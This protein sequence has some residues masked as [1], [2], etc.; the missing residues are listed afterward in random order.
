MAGNGKLH[1]A[2]AAKKD[3]FYTRLTD[4]EKELKHYKKHFKDKVVFCNCDDPEYSEFYNYFHLNFEEL[5]LKKLI[6]THYDPLEPTYK[7]EI[8]GDLNGDGKIDGSDVVR[9]RLMQNGDFRSD[10]C[11]EL[12][13]ESDIVVGNPPFSLYREYVAQLVEYKKQFLIIGNMNSVTYKEIFPLLKEGKIWAGYS[14]N[15]TMAFAVP[16]YYDTKKAIGEDR[17]G[18][19]IVKVPA[20]C[21]FTNLDIPKRHEKLTL[22]QRY[23]DD[24]GNPLPDV[25]ERYPHYDNYNAINCDKVA[26]IPVDYV[27]CWFKCPSANKCEWAKAGGLNDEI[28]ALCEQSINGCMGVPIAR[29][30]NG[31]IGTSITICDRFFEQFDIIGELNHGKDSEFDFADTRVNGKLKFKRILIRR[32]M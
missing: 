25:E 21:W 30:C 4:I 18:R 3:E 27:P 9:T 32:K 29:K 10:E 2:K 13:K 31:L 28:P 20:I 14:F 15:K 22:W 16:P 1:T 19:K 8:M 5:G 12:L 7:L 17:Y 26:D 24:D 23:Y 11:I 6:C